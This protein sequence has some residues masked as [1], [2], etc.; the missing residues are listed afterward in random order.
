MRTPLLAFLLV[1]LGGCANAGGNPSQLPY[2]YWRLGFLAPDHMEAWVETSDVEDIRGRNFFHVGSGT[3]S[4]HTPLDGTGNAFGWRK[5]WGKGRYVNGADLPKR[6][7]IRWQSLAEPQ[8]YRVTLDISERTRQLMSER[9][10]PPCRTSNYRNALALGLAP[11]GIVRG[12]V[13]S[14]CDDAIEVLRVQ[15]EIEPKGPY[16]GQ[17]G[18]EYYFLSDESKA[19]IE[20]YGIPYGSW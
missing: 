5:G 18:G 9:L 10:E 14:P 13:M 8:T 1:L 17:S 15:A 16:D 6:I 12:W 3:V 2:Q 11:G 4:V 20:K 19:Y 7:F